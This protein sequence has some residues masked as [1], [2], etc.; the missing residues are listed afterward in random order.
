MLRRVTP[1][2]H[3]HASGDFQLQVMLM[4]DVKYD[5]VLVNPQKFHQ[6]PQLY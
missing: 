1:L 4:R 5:E 3:P 6:L 2:L